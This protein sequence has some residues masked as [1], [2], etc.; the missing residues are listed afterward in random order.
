MQPHLPRNYKRYIEPFLGGGSLFFFLRPEAAVLSDAN[1]ELINTF[2]EVRDNVEAIIT[3]LRRWEYSKREY[4]GIRDRYRPRTATTAAARFIYL[5]KTCW[6]GLYRVNLKGKFNVPFGRLKAPY[7]IRE[8]ELRACSKVLKGKS[9]VVAGFEDA[10]ATAQP[11]DFIYLDPPYVTGH[12]NNGFVEYN[13]KLFTWS[14]QVCL[15]KL[16]KWLLKKGVK[17]AVTNAAHDAVIRLYR[18]FKNIPLSRHSTIAGDVFA[19]RKSEEIL[20][21]GGY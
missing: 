18:G 1:P 5:N 15:A 10:I 4:Y 9:I 20:F 11:D 2:I 3:V 19:R 8:D 21:K 13:A 16:A 12:N 7:A 17:V 14:D 6:N